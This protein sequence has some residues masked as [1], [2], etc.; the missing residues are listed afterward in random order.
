[1]YLNVSYSSHK[2]IYYYHIKHNPVGFVMKTQ[3]VFYNI[4]LNFDV[5]YYIDAFCASKDIELPGWKLKIIT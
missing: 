2:I 5:D 1:V 3:C 4:E